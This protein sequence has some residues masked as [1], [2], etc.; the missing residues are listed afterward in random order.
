MPIENERKFVLEDD[1]GALERI[2]AETP[3]VTRSYLRQAYLD[4]SGLRIRTHGLS[5]ASLAPLT[6]RVHSTS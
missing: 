6:R 3:G 5:S 4:S 2:L 1:E